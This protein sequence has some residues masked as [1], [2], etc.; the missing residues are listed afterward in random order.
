M[1]TEETLKLWHEGTQRWNQWARDMLAQRAAIIEEDQETWAKKHA[2]DFRP[3]FMNARSVLFNERGRG[4]INYDH[5]VEAW[6]QSASV[7]FCGHEFTETVEFGNP[8]QLGREIAI[9]PYNADFSRCC[10][11]NNVAFI[12]HP[13]IDASRPI[14][15]DTHQQFG[16]YLSFFRA[17]FHNSVHIDRM[18]LY[19][20]ISFEQAKFH[21]SLIAYGFRIFG[22]SWF[23]DTVFSAPVTFKGNFHN[24]V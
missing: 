19:G 20:D 16:G 7:S 6:M 15:I 1:N 18:T 22:H 11:R 5:D 12:G 23:I 4:R 8:N 2:H 9:F 24:V 10:F 14:Y 21:N 17:E 13:Y 3:E